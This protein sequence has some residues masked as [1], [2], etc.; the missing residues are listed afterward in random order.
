MA[1]LRFL[2]Q[3][4]L[5]NFPVRV[6]SS[7]SSIWQS[8]HQ[9]SKAEAPRTMSTLDLLRQTPSQP[10]L[11]NMASST[12]VPSLSSG[13]FVPQRGY[14]VK[15]RIRR[16][17]KDCYLV[18]IDGLLNNLCKTH[19]RHKQRQK[20]PYFVNMRILSGVCNGAPRKPW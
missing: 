17:C 3:G 13:F 18:F 8:R 6:T 19:G 2:G 4:S 15:A 12:S 5:L 20:P 16:R 1:L 7:I 14:K 11:F 9:L 10:Q